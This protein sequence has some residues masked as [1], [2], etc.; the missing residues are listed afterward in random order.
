[1]IAE[2]T[3]RESEQEA[4]QQ[5]LVALN[6][7]QQSKKPQLKQRKLLLRVQKN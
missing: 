4:N 7:A 3:A 6:A 2:E 5:R 1:L